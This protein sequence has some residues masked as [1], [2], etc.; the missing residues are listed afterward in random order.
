M[1]RLR[2]LTVLLL[3]CTFVFL[4]VSC[5]SGDAKAHEKVYAYL[6]EK[7]KGV[8]FEIVE[9]TQEV[10]TSGKHVFRVR[11]LATNVTF[12]VLMTSMMTTDSYIVSHANS[13][14]EQDV[15]EILG[16]ARPLMCLERVQCFNQYVS[17]DSTY[18]FNEDVEL[19][20]RSLYDVGEIYR[21]YL[22]DMESSN[23]AAQCVY[24]FCDILSYR[25]VVLDQITFDFLLNGEKIRFTT[26]TETIRGMNSFDELQKLL[27][28]TNNVNVIGEFF[29]KDPDSNTKVF[30]YI[31]K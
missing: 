21:V 18:R 9:H 5:Q 16:D 24:M 1:K 28:S 12:D 22:S 13:V 17:E 30:Q 25:G 19:T 29:Y 2:R 7:Y 31:T 11:C 15:M 14:I 3:A 8:E 23:E 27:D 20:S 10:E 6:S 4:T 26:S